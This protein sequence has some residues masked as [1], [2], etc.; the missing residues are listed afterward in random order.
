MAV[1]NSGPCRA[2]AVAVASVA[3]IVAAGAAAALVAPA[4][5]VRL[6]V[7]AVVGGAPTQLLKNP[8]W[9]PN[10]LRQR[11]RVW[12][13]ILRQILVR[14]HFAAPP[15]PVVAAAA[16]LPFKLVRQLLQLRQRLTMPLPNPLWRTR[17]I[18]VS[19]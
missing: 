7:V 13:R 10:P 16:V 6:S 12:T 17:L 8:V 15:Q 18:R 11:Q 4:G 5:E 1:Q 9:S 14:V 2:V 3:V 19:H